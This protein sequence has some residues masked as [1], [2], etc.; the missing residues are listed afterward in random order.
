MGAQEKNFQDGVEAVEG[1]NQEDDDREYGDNNH[2]DE[3]T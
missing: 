2:S 1:L 3:I